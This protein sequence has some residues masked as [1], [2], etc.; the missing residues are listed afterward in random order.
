MHAWCRDSSVVLLGWLR[1]RPGACIPCT[2]RIMRL[3]SKVNKYVRSGLRYSCVPQK[4]CVRY[5]PACSAAVFVAVTAAAAAAGAAAAAAM[6]EAKVWSGG[7]M[8]K[9]RQS[10]KSVSR[11]WPSA[12]KRTFYHA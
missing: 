3:T 11:A 12:P 6:G 2:N 9:W 5:R 4:E 7:E 8:S 1:K 10:P